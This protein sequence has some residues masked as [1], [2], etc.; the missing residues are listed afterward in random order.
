MIHQGPQLNT[1]VPLAN[2]LRAGLE[3]NPT[4]NALVAQDKS[5]S[6]QE[7]DENSNRL[8]AHFLALGLQPGDRV[9]S[10][11][12]NRIELIVYYIAMM[13][14]GLVFVPLNYRYTSVTIDNVLAI[15]GVNALLSHTERAEDI[16]ASSCAQQ[17]R[18]GI[19]WYGDAEQTGHRLEDWLSRASTTPFTPK[20]LPI[21]TPVSIFFT[22][23]STGK[24]KGV[25]HSASSWAAIFASTVQAIAC[26]PADR[27]MPC[28]SLAHMAAFFLLFRWLIVRCYGGCPLHPRK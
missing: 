5:L 17:L 16:A 20:P 28:T 18:Y 4:G 27:L 13:K 21:D 11:M 14:A 23:G 19:I 2:L 3:H 22:S 24:P 9:A 8:A 15:S 1:P 12:P 6:W 26:R 25:I 7:L 10:L